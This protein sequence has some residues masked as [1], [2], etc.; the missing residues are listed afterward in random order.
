MSRL[1]RFRCECECISLLEKSA[2]K[3]PHFF[4][5]IVALVFQYYEMGVPEL[6]IKYFC[7]IAARI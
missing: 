1:E 6:A 7:K 3:R 4:R 5:A 2:E